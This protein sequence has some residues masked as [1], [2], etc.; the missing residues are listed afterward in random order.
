M[1]G[2]EA[3]DIAGIDLPDIGQI[4]SVYRKRRPTIPSWGV[5]NALTVLAA[6]SG[7]EPHLHAVRDSRMMFSQV[8][9]R[10]QPNCL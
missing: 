2:L 4:P 1:K 3:A 5:C 8:D 10:Q 7:E 9:D 6:G